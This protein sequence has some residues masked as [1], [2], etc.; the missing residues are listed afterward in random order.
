M[1]AQL[2]VLRRKFI[3]L[4]VNIRKEVLDLPVLRNWKRMRKINP[5][6]V[7]E[8]KVK[9]WKSMNLKTKMKQIARSSKRTKPI[10]V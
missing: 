2:T 3:A 6:L 7:E 10:N 4:S 9:G 5:Q 8:K 1:W